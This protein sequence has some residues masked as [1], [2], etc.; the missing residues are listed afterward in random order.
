MDAWPKSAFN[1]THKEGP[2]YIWYQLLCKSPIMHGDE[3]SAVPGQSLHLRH[4]WRSPD[5]ASGTKTRQ[6]RTAQLVAKTPNHS[7]IFARILSI[8]GDFLYL[9]LLKGKIFR[10]NIFTADPTTS[11]LFDV[12]R[13]DSYVPPVR[14]DQKYPSNICLDNSRG[15]VILR[16]A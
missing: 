4:W 3:C 1:N 9:P 5:R 12:G 2:A 11:L 8:F 7:T 15:H 16:I 13:D 14:L 6:L 10:L